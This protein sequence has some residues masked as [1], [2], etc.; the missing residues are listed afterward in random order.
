MT[1]LRKLYNFIEQGLFTVAGNLFL[2]QENWVCSLFTIYFRAFSGAIV[3]TVGSNISPAL[4]LEWLLT[5]MDLFSSALLGVISH[6][7]EANFITS[8]YCHELHLNKVL[9]LFTKCKALA[10]YLRLI[11]MFRSSIHHTNESNH[12]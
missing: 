10:S 1:L 7:T 11:F 4:S 6:L 2:L 5:M 3:C 8:L 12:H 9:F